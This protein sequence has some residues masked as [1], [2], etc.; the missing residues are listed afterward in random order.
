[1]TTYDERRRMA[2]NRELIELRDVVRRV[3][4]V[5]SELSTA[6]LQLDATFQRLNKI[7]QD[8]DKLDETI[9]NLE[10]KLRKAKAAS[11][12]VSLVWKP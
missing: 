3:A 11:N 10:D 1:M 6:C 7:A 4:N 5:C 12:V 2:T 9:T 8:D